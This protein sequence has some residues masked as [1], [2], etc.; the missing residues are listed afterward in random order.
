MKLT[1]FLFYYFPYSVY[2]Y[3]KDSFSI[4]FSSFSFFIFIISINFLSFF[5]IYNTF[6]QG[7]NSLLTG[8]STNERRFLI[9][10]LLLLPIIIFVVGFYKVRKETI[11]VRF[12]AYDDLSGLQRRKLNSFSVVLIVLSISLFILA[13]TSSAWVHYK[14]FSDT[15]PRELELLIMKNGTKIKSDTVYRDATGR[16]WKI[17]IEGADSAIAHWKLWRIE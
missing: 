3:Y 8:Y 6:I 12:K 5:L 13:I 17:D 14:K 11:R 4:K 7:S 9:I 15:P 1:E 16:L 2:S 10:P